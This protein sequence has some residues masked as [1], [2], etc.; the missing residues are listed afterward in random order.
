MGDGCRNRQWEIWGNFKMVNR[1]QQIVADRYGKKVELRTLMDMDLV[2]LSDE[3]R[4]KNG[5]LHIPLKM[6]KAYL[7]T[8]LVPDANDLTQEGIQGLSELVKLI[9][10]PS[11]FNT[12]LERKEENLKAQSVGLTNDSST[13]L[14]SSIFFLFGKNSTLTKKVAFSLHELTDRWAFLPWDDIK[15]QVQST[16]DLLQM[17]GVTIFVQDIEKLSLKHQNLILEYVADPKTE[18][19]PIF[20]CTSSLPV[21]DLQA[22]GMMPHLCDELSINLFD[23]EKA[24]TNPALLNQVLEIFFFKTKDGLPS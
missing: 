16:K 12:F 15:D 24:P 14:L 22:A 5:T 6:D 2:A 21:T 13:E 3:P 8:A 11:L 20:V 23:V 17:G 9:L 1:L 18:E 7:G 19:Q 4:M 10:E